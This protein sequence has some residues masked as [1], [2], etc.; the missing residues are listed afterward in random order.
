M[1]AVVQRVKRAGVR[2]EG[3][4]RGSI[5]KGLLVYLGVEKGDGPEDL[6]YIAGKLATLRVFEDASGRMNH[7]IK[8]SGGAF[9]IISQFTLVGDMRKGRR[10]SFEAA[11]NPEKALALYKNLNSDLREKG[12]TVAEGEFGAHMEVDSINDGPVTILLDSR[13]VF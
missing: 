9:L 12:F 1:R 5:E 13:K 3:A 6:E 4:Q 10:P 7:D 11:E 8:E 2:V